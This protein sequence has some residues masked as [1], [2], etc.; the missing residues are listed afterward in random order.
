MYDAGRVGHQKFIC[1]V[2]R[3]DCP[4][5]RR[6]AGCV[7]CNRRWITFDVGGWLHVVRLPMRHG[8]NA[9]FGVNPEVWS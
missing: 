8:V 7:G 2:Q 4:I 3:G 5:L 1:V 9:V 6:V